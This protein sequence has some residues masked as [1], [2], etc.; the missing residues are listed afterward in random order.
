MNAYH[1]IRQHLQPG[2]LLIIM[3]FTKYHLPII[4]SNAN[5]AEGKIITDYILILEWKDTINGE[6]HHLNL[7]LLC[8]NDITNTNDYYFI[9]QSWH[10]LFYMTD[11]LT[12]FNHIIIWSD[13]GPY[14]FPTRYTQYLFHSLAAIFHKRITHHLFEAYHGHS[15]ADGHAGHIK[16]IIKHAFINEQGQRQK[17][18]LH[19]GPQNATELKELINNET[20]FVYLFP[21]V[22]RDPFHKPDVK[23]IPN[24][25]KYRCFDYIYNDCM[26]Y[27]RS[28]DSACIGVPHIFR[29]RYV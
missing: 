5:D 7:D 16:S 12:K 27:E 2:Q 26:M 28:N 3:D 8:D 22:I 1:Y 23:S 25:S 20:T 10:F 29:F 17:G 24:I 14:Q 11:L 6:L 19:D 4:R 9:A 15:M 13:Q 21:S 18:E